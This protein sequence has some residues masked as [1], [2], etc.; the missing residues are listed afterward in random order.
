[1]QNIVACKMHRLR[2]RIS[3]ICALE[4]SKLVH[5]V[6]GEVE[7]DEKNYSMCVFPS[8]KKYHYDLSASYNIGT[9]CFIRE[10]LKSLSV[11]SR[12]GM[13]AKVLSCAK[14]PPAPYPS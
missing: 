1:M 3:R 4:T 5:D 10:I 2:K 14:R 8:E 11:T 13:E 12:L 6:S 9:R 7:R